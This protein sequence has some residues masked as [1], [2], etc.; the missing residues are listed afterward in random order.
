MSNSKRTDTLVMNKD[1][2]LKLPAL[3]S[4]LFLNIKTH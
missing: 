2:F 1:I 4:T 3:G